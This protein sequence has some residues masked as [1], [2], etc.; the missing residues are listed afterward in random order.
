MALSVNRI[1][2]SSAK[3]AIESIMSEIPEI[4]TTA[5]Q[6][7]DEEVLLWVANSLFRVTVSADDESAEHVVF[8]DESEHPYRPNENVKKHVSVSGA[9]SLQISFDELSCLESGADFLAFYRDEECTKL[10]NKKLSWVLSAF[11][12]KY[13]VITSD[14]LMISG[15]S[16]TSSHLTA[17]T[18]KSGFVLKPMLRRKLGAIVL[19]FGPYFGKVE[20][21]LAFFF[22]S[23]NG[24]RWIWIV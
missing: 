4:I 7:Q 2:R 16:L 23:Y 21:Q 17:L 8:S 6:V 22:P 24:R 15:L 12:K 13:C 18:M 9:T 1:A 11:F 20:I 14:V 3:K 19:K 10:I 5:Q